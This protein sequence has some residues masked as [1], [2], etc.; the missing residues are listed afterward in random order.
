MTPSGDLAIPATLKPAEGG[1]LDATVLSMSGAGL[2]LRLEADDRIPV[3]GTATVDFDGRSYET[4]VAWGVDGVVGLQ[5]LNLF[6]TAG[7]FGAQIDPIVRSVKDP[8]DRRVYPRCTVLMSGWVRAGVVYA[9]CVVR[10][11]SLGGAKVIC[12]RDIEHNGPVVLHVPKFGDFDAT[13]TWR[14]GESFGLQFV[15]P[16]GAIAGVIGEALPRTIPEDFNQAAG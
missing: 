6:D 13:V 9:D 1:Q 2:C 8:R 14:S 3:G 4:A 7:E 11:I 15:D 5:V 10:N 16:P 12:R